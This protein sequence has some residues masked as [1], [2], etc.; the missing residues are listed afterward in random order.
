M[1]YL[2]FLFLFWIAVALLA[3]AFA[4]ALIGLAAI[5]AAVRY[6]LSPYRSTNAPH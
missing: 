5:R 4:F 6:L 2:L 1:K 3:F